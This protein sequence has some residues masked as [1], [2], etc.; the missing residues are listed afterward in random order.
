MEVNKQH[1]IEPLLLV[2]NG[3]TNSSNGVPS[4]QEEKKSCNKLLKWGPLV[5]LLVALFGVYM[6]YPWIV[7]K[8][9]GKYDLQYKLESIGNIKSDR[10]DAVITIENLPNSVWPI[11]LS[12]EDVIVSYKGKA[13]AACDVPSVWIAGNTKRERSLK[14]VVRITEPAILAD[15]L[16]DR[17][18]SDGTQSVHVSLKMLA[19]PQYFF[20]LLPMHIEKQ[21]DL[22]K[23]ASL[24]IGDLFDLVDIVGA[25]EQ[26]ITV[27]VKIPPTP[28]STSIDLV[29]A[30][31]TVMVE[32]EP[33]AKV[34]IKPHVVNLSKE[35]TIMVYVKP[36]K[37]AHF[38]NF[39][40]QA[41]RG[42]VVYTNFMIGND[43]IPF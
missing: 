35:N 18:I 25:D 6:E 13:F 37:G 30:S 21:I 3:E 20:S 24:P 15:I 12:F 36:V 27:Q 42:E 8:Y 40:S 2:E 16:K 32:R 5:L 1:E 22:P 31:V 38:S 4:E 33:I 7:S 9:A 43:R 14:M 23:T 29:H 19:K 34:S 39:L 10:L 11:K 26:T 28:M 41:M 17:L